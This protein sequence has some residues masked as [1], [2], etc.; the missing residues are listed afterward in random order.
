MPALN[1]KLTGKQASLI[2]AGILQ[3][4]LSYCTYGVYRTFHP[5]PDTTDIADY[6][7]MRT[8]F[9]QRIYPWAR[10]TLPPEIPASASNISFYAFPYAVL[11]G[12]PH[13][14]LQ[15]TL[16]PQEAQAEFDRLQSVARETEFDNELT[17]TIH[18]SAN[19][20]AYAVYDPHTQTFWYTLGSD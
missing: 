16:A 5:G 3:L 14:E 4:F 20:W 18:P 10:G 6:P 15:F 19:Q 2:F 13:L 9:E 12:R 17:F 1:P 11:Q 7:E 8:R